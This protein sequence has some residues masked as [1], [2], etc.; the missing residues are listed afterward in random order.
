[1]LEK[2]IKNDNVEITYRVAGEVPEAIAGSKSVMLVHGF[3]EDSQVWNA[4]AEKLAQDHR[5]ILPDLPGSGK[6]VPSIGDTSMEQLA[7]QL[8]WVIDAEQ[9]AHCCLIGHS[10]GGYVTLAFAE[11]YPELPR[12]IGLFHSTAFADSEEKK[13]ARRKNIEFIGKHGSKK[14]LEQSVPNLFAEETASKNPRLIRELIERYAE[15]SPESLVAYTRAMMDR[16]DRTEVLRK[17]NKPALLIFGEHDTAV[18]IEQGM[19]L[20]G[21]PPFPYIY[22]ATRSGHMGM[23]EEPEF[24]LKALQEFFSGQ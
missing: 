16:P 5:V 13:K 11:K 4:I 21:L 14:F 10:M 19:K 1:M 7:D 12:R 24:C 3:G 6:S 23:L 20:C 22:I 2:R 15:L 8:K 9:A 17:F 18:P